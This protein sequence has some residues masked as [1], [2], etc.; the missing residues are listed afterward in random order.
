LLSAGVVRLDCIEQNSAFGVVWLKVSTSHER[1]LVDVWGRPVSIDW[2]F[3][4]LI[5]IQ[6]L[7]ETAG[8][9]VEEVFEREP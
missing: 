9:T 6:S 4:Q 1:V 8:F 7:L 3:F 5:E 2:F